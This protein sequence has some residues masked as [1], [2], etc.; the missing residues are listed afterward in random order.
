MVI[1]HGLA[2]LPAVQRLVELAIDE[3]LGRGD[4]TSAATVGAAEQPATAHLVARQALTF[5]GADLVAYV[6]SRID[7]SLRVTLHVADGARLTRGDKVATIVGRARGI[8][9]AERTAL[10]FAQRLSGVATSASAYA[11]A[12]AGTAARVV[13][14]RKTTPGYRVLEKAAVVAGGCGNH[15][16]D[17]GSGILIKDN[18]IAACGGV[19]EALAKAKAKAPHTLRIE[20][21]VDSLAM[22][23][24]ALACG[25]DTVLLD[26][27][28]PDLVRQA[29]PRCRQAG[30]RVEVSGGVTLASVRSFAEAGA[31]YISV[32]A[33]TH[34][35]PAV[36][37]ALDFA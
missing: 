10:N 25:V 8:L 3:D 12:V 21:E 18:H 13:D 16:A 23:D 20:I 15:R 29:V 5:F 37:L 4:V 31:D 7:P 11:A 36:D 19:T 26:N 24:E 33:L 30:V 34:S 35:A 32:G 17:L 27:F 14:T 6:F 22:L 9:E 28:S 2:A 1:A